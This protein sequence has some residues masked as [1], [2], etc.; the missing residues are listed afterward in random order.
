[1]KIENQTLKMTFDVAQLQTLKDG[2]ELQLS[3]ATS[4]LQDPNFQL[5]HESLKDMVEHRERLSDLLTDLKEGIT[6]LQQKVD[7]FEYAQS[8][9]EDELHDLEESAREHG[10][11]NPSGCV[12]SC[13][14]CQVSNVNIANVRR[15]LELYI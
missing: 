8:L 13:G 7:S 14:F 6:K 11:A 1:M 2:V 4:I 3:S 15:A 5:D 12:A 9:L 10:D